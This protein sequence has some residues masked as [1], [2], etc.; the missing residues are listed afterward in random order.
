MA[1]FTVCEEVNHQIGDL[2]SPGVLGGISGAVP[3]R[4]PTATSAAGPRTAR[5]DLRGPGGNLGAEEVCTAISEWRGVRK[6]FRGDANAG[7][8]PRP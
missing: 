8:S 7:R 3:L 4:Q 5:R 6:N 2:E 1:L